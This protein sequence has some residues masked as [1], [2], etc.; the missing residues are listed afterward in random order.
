MAAA[1]AAEERDGAL[2]LAEFHATRAGVRGLVDSGITTVPPLF[3]APPPGYYTP[4]STTA[5]SL[6]TI[7]TVDLSL[8]RAATVALVRAAARSHGFF[9]VTNHGVPPSTVSSAVSAI[10]A[11]HDHP[12]STTTRTACYSLA[13]VGGVSYATIPIQYSPQFPTP[14]PVLPWRDTLV[15]RFGSGDAPPDLARLPADCRDALQEYHRALVGIGREIAG[16]LSEAL[17]VGEERLER[18]MKVDGSLMVCH[19]YPPCPEPEKVVGSREHTDPSLFTVLAQ[20]HVGGLQVWQ[21]EEDGGGGEWVDVAPVAGALL[22]NIGDVLKVVSNDEYK[23]VEHRVVL[24][25]SEEA[26]VTIA[27]FFN[28]AKRDASDLFGPL[29]ELV[30]TERPAR[31]RCFSM[32]EFMRSRR[33]SGHGKSIVDSFKIVAD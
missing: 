29:E 21:E 12:S 27:L 4:S 25:S 2:S 13:S 6:A 24:K 32:L 5:S 30:T 26:R 8:P 15:V 9:H 31:Y 19:Y 33:E 20:D 1:A 16:L 18:E 28:P 17:G 14:S 22:V 3:L 7:P 11:F 10:H 23:S